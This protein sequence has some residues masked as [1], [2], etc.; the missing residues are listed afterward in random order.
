MVVVMVVLVVVVLVIV[1]GG[2]GDG[3]E[4]STDNDGGVGL[5]AIPRSPL[6]AHCV[7]VLVEQRNRLP[8]SHN[9]QTIQLDTVADADEVVDVVAVGVVDADDD[10]VAAAVDADVVPV[11][12]V[13]VVGADV[14]D[15]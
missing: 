3:K 1:Q 14:V 9:V 11:A 13:A 7:V 5:L 10:D 12:V 4:D 15:V 2:D 8:K 6:V